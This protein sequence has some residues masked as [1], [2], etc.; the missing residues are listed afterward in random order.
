[1]KYLD[2]SGLSH[3]WARLKSFF[4]AKNQ[5]VNNA[6]TTDAGYVLD[7]RVG[8]SLS[9]SINTKADKTAATTSANGLMSAADK[10]KLDGIGAG[11]NVKSVNGKTG[12]VSLSKAD[13][14]L[15]NVDNTRDADKHVLANNIQWG[16]NVISGSVSP[17]N[18]A[19]FNDMAAN[20]LAFSNP[21][22]ITVEYS[23]DGGTT[24]EDYGCDNATKIS[25]VT[26]DVAVPHLRLGKKSTGQTAGKDMLRITFDAQAMPV[27][28]DA[29]Y[30]LIRVAQNGARCLFVKLEYALSES[31][32]TFNVLGTFEIS[33][34][35][36]WSSIP[37]ERLNHF[38]G[39]ANQNGKNVVV[40]FTYYFNAYWASEF[41]S[42]TGSEILSIL[43]YAPTKWVAP[44]DL[45]RTGNIYSF[46]IDQNATFPAKVTATSFSGATATSS[47]DG[48]MSKSD[49]AKLDGIG[50]GSNV[51][52]VNGKTGAVTLAKG[53]VGLGSVTNYD[54]SKAIKSITRSGTTFT[55][56]SLDGTTTTFTQQDSNTTYS[57][58]TSSTDGLMSKS[59]KAK[60]DGVA[61]GADVSQI[62]TVK[63]N[64]TALTPDSSKAVNVTVPTLANNATTT[65][66]GM[67][68]DARMG[69]TL[70]DQIS[71]L[72]LDAATEADIDGCITKFAPAEITYNYQIYV[73]DSCLYLPKLTTE[74]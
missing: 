54:Q 29:K 14:G 71:S 4:I 53:D 57:V 62:K 30:F 64:G 38:G 11:S 69:K 40:R 58:A 27:Y 24:W 19:M 20:A 13:V 42:K 55:A 52:S 33:G 72:N 67:A 8:K 61:A 10:S 35:S 73:Q 46:D 22:G 7:A 3:L 15:G 32:T 59:D 70:S 56:T 44:S 28:C 36:G 60:L 6:A 1:M 9:D 41:E 12:V 50:A 47:A 31:K 37:V 23:N 63:V 34:W 16:G 49:K 17:L 65:T 26:Q 43:L 66:G 51:K 48:L 45:A 21:D 5:V 18:A 2:S 39:Y 25:L 68:L 74:A